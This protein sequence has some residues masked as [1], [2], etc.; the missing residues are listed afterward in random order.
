MGRT[1]TKNV[2]VLNIFLGGPMAAIQS[3]WANGVGGAADDE[4]DKGDE[5]PSFNILSYNL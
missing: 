3:V 2:H 1:N 4:D 5:H